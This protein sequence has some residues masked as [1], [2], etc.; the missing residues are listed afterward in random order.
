MV[1]ADRE[2]IEVTNTSFHF[3][4]DEFV[5]I[6]ADVDA[7]VPVPLTTVDVLDDASFVVASIRGQRSLFVR[8]LIATDEVDERIEVLQEGL[9]GQAR[10]TCFVGDRHLSRFIPVPA[11]TWLPVEGG[12]VRLEEGPLG[13]HAA[14]RESIEDVRVAVNEIVRVAMASDAKEHTGDE[15]DLWVCIVA[16]TKEAVEGITV[17]HDDAAHIRQ[18]NGGPDELRGIDASRTGELID[19][20]VTLASH[21]TRT[22]H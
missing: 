13:T 20:L 11:T 22:G 9:V 7:P 2:G 21:V 18:P 16:I 3:T 17:R 19:L 10:L 12:F 4:D 14:T 15:L 8:G 5:S 1:P 6:A